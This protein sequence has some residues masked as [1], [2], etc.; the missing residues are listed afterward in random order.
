MGT[1]VPPCKRR[2]DGPAANSNGHK[3]RLQDQRHGSGRAALRCIGHVEPVAP[4]Q[5]RR[6][7]PKL[8]RWLS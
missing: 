1:C 4:G 3:Q 5:R 8:Q 2:S 6:L 7:R